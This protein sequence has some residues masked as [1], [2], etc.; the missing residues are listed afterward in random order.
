[1]DDNI[2]IKVQGVSKTFKDQASATTIKHSFIE[3][4][5][6]IAGKPEQHK[7]KGFTALKDISFEVKKGEFF[8][9]VGR[10]GSGKSTLLKMIAGVYSPTSGNIQVN[11]QLTPFIELGVGFNP[12]LNGKDNVYLNSALLGFTHKQTDAMYKDIVEF[13]ELEQFMDTKLKNY[14]SG[15][16][17]R[18]AFSVAIRAKSD[19]LLL[20]E[21]LAVGDEAFQ[22]KCNI[23]FDKIK[24][25]KTK[26]IVLVTHDMGSIKKYCDKAVLIKDGVILNNGSPEDVANEYSLEN[27]KTNKIQ[28]IYKTTPKT[29]SVVNDYALT[30][31]PIDIISNDNILKI[32]VSYNIDKIMTTKINVSLIDIDRNVPLIAA[33]KIFKDKK[34]IK[35]TLLVNLG[36]INDTNIKILSTVRD[37][38]DKILY[39]YPEDKSPKIM[40][41]RND[42]PQKNKKTKWALLFD[43]GEWLD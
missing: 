29:K 32:K 28:K 3:L 13:A 21:I 1:M 4:G 23:F 7:K 42:Y 35:T 33:S 26:T 5:R 22:R 15:M 8:G 12:E 11:G 38:D 36:M 43:R 34:D 20:D 41:N 9:I 19:I 40:M 25:D 2:A 30:T 27:L 39:Y 6:K 31:L 10:N 24:K 18:L 16:Q 37:V 17:V 14:S